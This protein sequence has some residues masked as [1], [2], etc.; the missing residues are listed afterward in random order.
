MRVRAVR[1][2]RVRA[3]RESDESPFRAMPAKASRSE[4]L[5]RAAR[6]CLDQLATQSLTQQINAAPQNACDDS[7]ATAGRLYLAGWDDW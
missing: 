3:L 5:I 6:S 2:M 1:V 4:F 7:R